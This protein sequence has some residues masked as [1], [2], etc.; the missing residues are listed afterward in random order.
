MIAQGNAGT[1]CA[2]PHVEHWEAW[3]LRALACGT[4]AAAPVEGYLTAIH[5]Q[6]AKLPP[7]LLVVAWVAVR[8]R[9]RQAPWPHSIHLV[10]AAL[11]VVLLVSAAMH[12]HDSFTLAYTQRW[13]P[14]LAVTVVLIDLAAQEVPISTLLAAAVGGATAAGV[15]ALY[16]LVAAGAS[17]A[18]GPLEDPNDLAYVLV[19]ALPLAVGLLPARWMPGQRA[20]MIIVAVAV[21][22]LVTGTAA[23]FSRGGA[24]ALVVAVAWMVLRRALPL[25]ALAGALAGFAVV[26]VAVVLLA[27]PHLTRSLQEKNFIASSNVDS[28][29][30]RWQ[31]AARLMAEHPVLGVGPGGFRREYAVASHDAEVDEQTPVAHNMFLEVGAELGLPAFMLF[32]GLL[33]AGLVISER[34]IRL[35]QDHQAMAAVQ[36]SLIAAAV[37]STFL[38]EQ[39]Y[40]PLWSLVAFAVAADLRTHR[41]KGA[42]DASTARHQ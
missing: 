37:A 19:V 7:A 21:A 38:S 29:E 18:N 27:G 24:L 13:L 15:G 14:F 32:V 6:L 16:S 1:I 11:T 4:V 9:R 28:R 26:G 35:N 34:V 3:L 40:L 33:A 30:F 23:T 31:A 22:V 42:A 8:I 17:R 12:A 25:R 10:L 20:R 36:A 41:G 2:P 5:G 39:Y